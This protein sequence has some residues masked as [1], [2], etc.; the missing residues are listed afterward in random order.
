MYR[1][2][3]LNDMPATLSHGQK[4]VEMESGR[5]QTRH[6]RHIRMRYAGW[7]NQNGIDA[8]TNVVSVLL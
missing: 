2:I 6:P 1:Q 3:D 4:M 8:G 7:H 5:R